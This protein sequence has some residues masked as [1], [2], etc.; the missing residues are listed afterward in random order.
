[1]FKHLLEAQEKYGHGTHGYAKCAEMSREAAANQPECAA[2]YTLLAML[3]EDFIDRTE[4]MAVS[5]TETASAFAKYSDA[6]ALL[7]DAYKASNAAD[8]LAALNTMAA[9][10][11]A[12]D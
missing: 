12:T 7:D 9:S 6:V 11:H 5:S 2:A 8:I 10:I 4:R 1:L 3:A